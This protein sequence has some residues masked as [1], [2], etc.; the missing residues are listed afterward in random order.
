MARQQRDDNLSGHRAA[1]LSLSL[2]SAADSLRVPSLSSSLCVCVC[3]WVSA[4]NAELAEWFG[5]TDPNSSVTVLSSGAP[6]LSSPS[7]VPSGLSVPVAAAATPRPRLN[8]T[9]LI[10][11]QAREKQKNSSNRNNRTDDTAAATAA[12]DAFIDSVAAPS[13]SVASAATLPAPPQTHTHTHH[14]YH[15]H[16]RQSKETAA[17]AADQPYDSIDAAAV[18]SSSSVSVSPSAAS[19]S[20][21][22]PLLSRCA[23]SAFAALWSELWMRSDRN[24]LSALAQQRGWTDDRTTEQGAETAAEAAVTEESEQPTDSAAP[25]TLSALP[26]ASSFRCPSFDSFLYDA[27]Q[28]TLLL[29]FHTSSATSCAPSSLAAVPPSAVGSV[30]T[31]SVPASASVTASTVLCLTHWLRFDP[32][33]RIAAIDWE[34]THSR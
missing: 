20:V 2:P 16:T 12:S 23:V 24:S 5:E 11:R 10:I 27:H 8:L 19:S 7:S 29:R 3:Q 4:A 34:T 6:T 33:G 17:T 13:A 22:V 30:S 31:V 25:T 15:Y 9:E 18:S 26:L 21:C 1:T 14:H 32:H 28:R